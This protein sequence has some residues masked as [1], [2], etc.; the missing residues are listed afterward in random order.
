M[1][2]KLTNQFSYNGRWMVAP[3][4]DQQNSGVFDPVKLYTPADKRGN[5]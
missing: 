1:K 4:L 2:A 3:E 5:F